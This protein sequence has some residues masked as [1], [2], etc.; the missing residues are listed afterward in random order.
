MVTFTI[1]SLFWQ[2]F[3]LLLHFGFCSDK[4][5]RRN[6]WKAIFFFWPLRG[7]GG[8]GGGQNSLL[9]HIPL[10]NV[11]KGLYV[12]IY[13]SAIPEHSF[14]ISTLIPSLKKI[15]KGMP[16]IESENQFLMSIKGRYSVQNCQNLPICDP[17]ALLPNII[18]HIKFKENWLKN[19]PCRE[20]KWCADG[21]MYRQTD[22]GTLERIFLI[23][24]IT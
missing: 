6:L 3:L 18:S 22:I 13:P 20:W 17:R 1:F 16:K 4:L 15:G 12:K 21:R 23:E 8:G 14:T 9:M 2:R 10:S 5:I 19:A 11:N 7:W 24:G